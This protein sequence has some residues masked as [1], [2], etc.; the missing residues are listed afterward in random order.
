[1][2]D[3]F[4]SKKKLPFLI[5]RRKTKRYTFFPK[6]SF[7][8]SFLLLCPKK[9]PLKYV[10]SATQRIVRN[11]TVFSYPDPLFQKIRWF[12]QFLHFF[13]ACHEKSEIRMHIRQRKP[14]DTYF[15]LVWPVKK[16]FRPFLRRALKE[17]K[18]PISKY[19]KKVYRTKK[20]RAFHLI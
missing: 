11:Y 17:F 14:A 18:G 1:M 10:T 19:K 4:E 16:I 9:F 3:I 6:K 15:F 12:Q 2:H 5:N 13:P 8:S 7:I 20:S